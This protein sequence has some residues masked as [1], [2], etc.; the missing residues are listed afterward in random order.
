[1]VLVS[2]SNWSYLPTYSVFCSATG[3]DWFFPCSNIG[4]SGSS[5]GKIDEGTIKTDW[6]S[7][8]GG[9]GPGSGHLAVT[10]LDDTVS[11][12]NVQALFSLMLGLGYILIT[13]VVILIG[14]QMLWAS[15]TLGR[16]M[17]WKPLGVC[18][19]VS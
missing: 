12:P 9:V 2:T 15:W 11:Q 8:D 6:L 13:P 7:G 4:Y 10:Y 18:S 17:P 5:E 14:Y 1:M 3:S 19:S 16:A